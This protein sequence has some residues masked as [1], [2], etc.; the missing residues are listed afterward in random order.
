VTPNT[1][2]SLYNQ[3]KQVIPGGVNSPVRAF[4]AVG[5][6]PLFIAEAKGAHIVDADGRRYVDYVGSWGPMILGHRPAAVIDAVASVLQRGTSFGA[7]TDIEVEIAA[8]IAEIVPSVDMVRMVNSGTEACM[9]AIRLARGYT[10]RKTVIK[11]NGC[12]HGHSDSLLIDAGSGVATF[13]IAGSPGI[14][15]EVARLTASI[16]F[17]DIDLLEQ[18][19]RS[20][21]P[22][23]IAAVIMEPVP[24]N[25]GLILPQTGFLQNVRELCTKHGI[26]LI[27]DEV[28]TGFRVSLGGAQER[29]DVL[30]DLCTF[31]KII[32]GGLPVG[33]FGGKADIMNFLAPAGPVYQAGTL[34][35]NPLAMAAGLATL[36]SL[37]TC[38][39]YAEL[40]KRGKQWVLGMRKAATEAGVDAVIDHCGSMVGM[41]FTTSPVNN[42]ADVQR[43]DTEVFKRYF[44]G[45]LDAGIYIAPSAFEV[46]FLSTAHTQEI[47]EETVASASYVLSQL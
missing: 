45:M 4:K 34:S 18:S 37:K 32:G 23:N 8:L 35:G 10:D 20:I 41:F 36:Q 46:G 47:V 43:A 3:A 1:S 17:N 14:P 30:P 38:N 33:A 12:Y 9:T 29:F 40:E 16:E 44:R 19:V 28:M 24:G 27:F 13:G 5:G 7:P 2:Q 22:D 15:P 26:I 21:G 11:F 42:Y 25:M 6:D 31:S 39:P